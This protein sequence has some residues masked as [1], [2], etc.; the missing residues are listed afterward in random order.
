MVI[1]GYTNQQA[2]SLQINEILVVNQFVLMHSTYTCDEQCGCALTLICRVSRFKSTH[3]RS[4]CS[5][6][7]WEYLQINGSV[8]FVLLNTNFSCTTIVRAQAEWK[9]V[10]LFEYFQRYTV[11][12][13]F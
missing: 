8:C 13:A 1:S 6:F 5:I 3:L 7:G 4:S 11:N 10:Q 2:L 12:P 9:V